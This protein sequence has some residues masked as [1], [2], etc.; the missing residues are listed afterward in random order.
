MTITTVKPFI[1]TGVTVRLSRNGMPVSVNIATGRVQ[2]EKGFRPD[3]TVRFSVQTWDPSLAVVGDGTIVVPVNMTKAKTTRKGRQ[4]ITVDPRPFTQFPHNSVI[5]NVH[6]VTVE[7]SLVCQVIDEIE[8]WALTAHVRNEHR[9][10][11]EQIAALRGGQAIV[12]YFSPANGCG[13]AIRK[14]KGGVP[15]ELHLHFSQLRVTTRSGLR[16]V[17][18]GSVVA[19]SGLG[20]IRGKRHQAE[21]VTLVS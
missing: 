21:N 13:V 6:G 10:S 1:P 18:P 16:R 11:A 15:E 20:R 17:A 9:P 4:T 19:F 5:L 14:G 12:V 2:I 8:V 7:I 3:D